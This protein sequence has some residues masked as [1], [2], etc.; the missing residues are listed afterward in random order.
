ML[1]IW[2][3]NLCLWR[4]WLQIGLSLKSTNN[5]INQRLW[6]EE[7]K[8]GQCCVPPLFP[9]LCGKSHDDRNRD[10]WLVGFYDWGEFQ[11]M[12]CGLDAELL[13]NGFRCG[14]GES[15]ELS[16]TVELLMMVISCQVRDEELQNYWV[17][18]HQMM[19]ETSHHPPPS[20]RA[21]SLS[22]WTICGYKIHST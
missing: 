1:T 8:V 2:G 12:G 10:I 17:S 15:V 19:R 13:W 14:S 16:S 7:I 18:D 5:Q 22:L 4:R 3:H 9:F 6:A 21:D 11:W 20:V